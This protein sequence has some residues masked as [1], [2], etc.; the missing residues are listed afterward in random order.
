M[1]HF[2]ELPSPVG[3][4]LLSG[5]EQG[6]RGISFQ[7][8]PHAAVPAAR[9]TRAREPFE[10]AIAQL[11]EYFA[12]TRRRFDLALA[13]EGSPFQC[14]VWAMLRRIPYGDTITYGEL[15]RRL[16]RSNAAR[17]VG[18]A[19]GRNPIP[20]VIPCHRVVGADGSLTGFGGGLDIKRRLLDLEARHRPARA[21]MERSLFEAA[22]SR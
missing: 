1:T 21:G 18:A 9:W 3:P 16:G 15:A 20:I 5:D 12:G 22:D 8:G 2:W 17:A 13:P 4:L 19:N 6:L 7:G 11:E 10:A 14:E